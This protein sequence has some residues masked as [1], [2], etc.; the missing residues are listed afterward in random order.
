M[1]VRLA[2]RVPRFLGRCMTPPRIEVVAFDLGGVLVQIVGSWAEAHSRAGIRPHP[3]ASDAA[4]LSKRGIAIDA[5]S[6]G[7]L[8]PDDY[9]R[10]VAEAS[11]GA[12]TADDIHRIHAAW[13]WAEYPGVDAVV[14][15]IEAAGIA[16]GALSNTSAPHWADRRG[17]G[18]QYP[19]VARLGH[20]VASH[21]VGVLKPDVRIFRAFETASGISGD[22]VLF[23]DDLPQNV[24]AARA[25][26]WH[27]ERIVPT[28]DTAAQL[29]RALR[30]HGALGVGPG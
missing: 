22:R 21:L 23:F 10:A 7:A 12:Y 28:T 9:Y 2:L 4:F 16:T 19:S 27:A 25:V 14:T 17:P 3:I 24:E 26:G 15:A 5:L 8:T 13:H 30:R 20:A 6:V 11:G 18:S 29:M 1:A